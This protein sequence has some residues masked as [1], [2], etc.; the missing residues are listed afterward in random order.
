MLYLFILITIII[1]LDFINFRF[2][3]ASDSMIEMMVMISMNLY[4]LNFIM[5]V[6][7]IIASVIIFNLIIDTTVVV[8][9]FNLMAMIIAIIIVATAIIIDPN[10]IVV[11]K[12]IIE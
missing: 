11:K 6:T 10:F 4:V 1:E 12:I 2:I 5:K 3:I 9:N 8:S 7:V